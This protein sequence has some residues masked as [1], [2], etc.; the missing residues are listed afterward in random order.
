[1][2]AQDM[3]TFHVGRMFLKYRA[4]EVELILSYLFRRVTLDNIAQVHHKVAI[5]QGLKGP[6]QFVRGVSKSLD[7]SF[8]ML[9]VLQNMYYMNT[10]S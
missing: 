6:F 3:Y 5:R 9:I 2:V 7:P 4:N 1:M 10:C 8:L